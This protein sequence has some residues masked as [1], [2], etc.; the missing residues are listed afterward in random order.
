MSSRADERVFVFSSGWLS[1]LI[2]VYERA[3]STAGRCAAVGA[4]ALKEGRQM[5]GRGSC[6]IAEQEMQAEGAIL[7]LLLNFEA[8][9]IWSVEEVVSQ[10]SVSRVEVI[11]GLASLQASGLIHRL[12]D[13]V[14]VTRAASRFDRLEL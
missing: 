2:G 10:L 3:G 9:S 5:S 11:D 13:F 4:S 14:F 6:V 7:G 12:E 8:G 1:S